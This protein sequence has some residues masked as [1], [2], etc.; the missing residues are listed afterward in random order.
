MTLHPQHNNYG[1]NKTDI[2]ISHLAFKQAHTDNTTKTNN[3]LKSNHQILCKNK[4]I[5]II[6]DS[7]YVTMY[8]IN[9][10]SAFSY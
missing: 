10:L 7:T 4:R 1:F 6:A 9:N 5:N 3:F 2:V 8:Y